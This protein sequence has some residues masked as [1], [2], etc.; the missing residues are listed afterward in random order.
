MY[1]SGQ[2]NGGELQGDCENSRGGEGGNEWRVL[3]VIL[4]DV[5]EKKGID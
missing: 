2:Q 5:S 1:Q 4:G 3:C